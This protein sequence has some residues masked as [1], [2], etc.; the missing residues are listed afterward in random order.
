MSSFDK[1][2]KY[3]AEHIAIVKQMT[4]R[5]DFTVIEGIDGP[6][7]QELGLALQEDLVCGRALCGQ[8]LDLFLRAYLEEFPPTGR[9]STLNS[10]RKTSDPSYLMKGR[11]L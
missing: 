6:K 8:A 10:S 1:P 9:A 11:T 4:Q 7:A 2:P 5:I 3:S